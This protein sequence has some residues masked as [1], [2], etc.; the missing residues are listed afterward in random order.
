MKF[1][2][3]LLVV[4][5]SIVFSACS[6]KEVYEPKLISG[7]WEKQDSTDNLIIDTTLDAAL[8]ENREVFIDGK[9]TGVKIDD[10]FL[11]LMVGL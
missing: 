3:L 7:E 11:I 4:T 8:L 10:S 5:I 9:L 6:S 1:I 2:Q